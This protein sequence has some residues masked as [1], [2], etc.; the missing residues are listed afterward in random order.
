MYFRPH[1]VEGADYAALENRPKSFNGLSVDRADNIL[2]SSVV[3]DAMWIFAVKTLVA[4]PLIGAKQA[5][6][7][8]NGFADEGSESIGI[9]IS[10]YPHDNVSLAADGA[11]DWGFAGTDTASSAATA[12]LIPM[13]V[14]GQAADESFI[15]FDNSAEL[16]NVFHEGGSNFMAHEPSGFI[17]TEAI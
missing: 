17:G 10:D 8:G 13:P 16:I 9:D 2:A 4:S 3:N 6:F 7:M 12:A 15:N 1:F 11:D 14:F 5:D